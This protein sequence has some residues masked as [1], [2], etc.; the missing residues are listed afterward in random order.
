MP[1]KFESMP[2]ITFCFTE[3]YLEEIRKIF[4][5]QVLLVFWDTSLHFMPD[6]LFSNSSAH[7][8]VKQ[9]KQNKS[10]N[11]RGVTI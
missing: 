1:L 11:G 6:V 8:T 2:K 9:T 5:L 4:A 7:D 3:D 10:L